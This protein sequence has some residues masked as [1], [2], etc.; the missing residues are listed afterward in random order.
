MSDEALRKIYA[1]ISLYVTIFLH[2]NT[3]LYYKE[4]YIRLYGRYAT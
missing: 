4:N 2:F 3:L 1:H